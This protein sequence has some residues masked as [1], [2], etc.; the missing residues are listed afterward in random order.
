MDKIIQQFEVPQAL[1]GQRLDKVA[2]TLF[3]EFSRA[4]L[5]RWITEGSL[6]KDGAA[7]A[8]K[9]KVHGGELLLLEADRSVREMWDEAQ[10]L[11]LDV[12]Y[13]D[14]DIIVLHKPAGL[15]VHPGAGNPAGTLVN[16]LLEHRAELR[17]L[18]RAGVVHRLDK[19]TSGVMVVAA[20]QLAL[21]QLTQMIQ[22]RAVE[23]RYLA[24][25]EGRMVAG[26]DVDEP[27]GRDPHV[28]TRQAVREDG[29]PA[30]T[31]FRIVQRFRVHTL[32]KARLGSGRTH[33]IRVH[34][35]SIGFPLVG[36][37]RY[38]ARGRLPPAAAPELIRTLQGFKRQA[39]HAHELEFSHPATQEPLHFS[40][41]VPDDLRRLLDHLDQDA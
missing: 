31:E 23:R 39:L 30:Y 17:S 24:L 5:A 37:R 11:A 35:K 21:R 18:P 26:V 13:E 33:Q 25:C 10:S 27:I 2:A 34:L 1:A 29:K 40:A 6:T 16:G 8:P 38:G 9:A 7:C 28:R 20:S 4:E 3:T 15:V 36:D 41:P 32:L 22:D 12:I 14:D 19:D